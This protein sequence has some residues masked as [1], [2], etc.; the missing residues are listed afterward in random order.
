MN[1]ESQR[2]TCTI[3]DRH[4]EIFSEI[5]R[6]IN[7][8]EDI[9]ILS[10]GCSNGTEIRTLR[11]KYFSDAIIDGYDIKKELVKSNN[12]ENSDPKINY[13]SDCSELEA[14]SYDIIFCMSVLCI[15]P[16]RKGEVYPFD[17][18][19]ESLTD[20]DELLK[21]GGYIVIYN[22]TY[23]F[24]DATVSDKYE[25]VDTTYQEEVVEREWGIGGGSGFV[26]KITKDGDIVKYYPHY[27]FKKMRD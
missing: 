26:P 1:K 3:Y 5:K 6:K 18:F 22:S 7:D 13:Y 11:E 10:F 12:E 25:A 15:W 23:R 27:L 8:D 2:S 4:P 9:K 16:L 14:R 24:S 21:V 17:L 19:D 20:I